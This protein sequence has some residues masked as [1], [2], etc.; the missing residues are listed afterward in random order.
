MTESLEKVNGKDYSRGVLRQV[1]GL[2]QSSSGRL[3]MKQRVV[4]E[5]SFTVMQVDDLIALKHYADLYL[6]DELRH[7][8]Y[9]IQEGLVVE[10]DLPGLAKA[11]VDNMVAGRLDLWGVM[12][13]VMREVALRYG[14]SQKEM[15]KIMGITPRMVHYYVRGKGS[16]K[17]GSPEIDNLIPRSTRGGGRKK[18]VK[19]DTVPE[20]DPI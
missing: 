10:K 8:G 6:I 4:L 12:R 9:E 15:A 7:R 19:P 3:N 16:R 2:E 11:L 13:E 5:Q 18:R 20:T 1:A 14:G 17:F